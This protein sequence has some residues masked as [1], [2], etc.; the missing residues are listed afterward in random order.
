MNLPEPK[1]PPREVAGNDG[2]NSQGGKGKQKGSKP[3]WVCAICKG[4]VG[5]LQAAMEQHQ[6]LNEWCI[7]HQIWGRMSP[8]EKADPGPAWK[9]CREMAYYKKCG[10]TSEAVENGMDP[11]SEEEI[12]EERT[13]SPASL[14]AASGVRLR[15]ASRGVSKPPATEPVQKPEKETVKKAKKKDKKKKKKTSK[16]SSTSSQEPSAPRSS[17]SK[18]VVINIG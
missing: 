3:F 17:K 12:L 16:S 4:K 2:K 14:P 15:A 9:K 13:Q 5:A 6:Y 1:N 18:K 8:Q 7:A 10:R 11:P